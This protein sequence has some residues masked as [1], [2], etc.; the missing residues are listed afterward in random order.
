M[1]KKKDPELKNLGGWNGK[2]RVHQ[3]TGLGMENSLDICRVCCPRKW[4]NS[5]SDKSSNR[6]PNVMRLFPPAII[7]YANGTYTI[8]ANLF[9]FI[10][11]Q[12]LNHLDW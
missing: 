8:R 12:E 9:S 7:I 2:D 11:N 3:V 6:N 4:A 10:F 5:I 1:R